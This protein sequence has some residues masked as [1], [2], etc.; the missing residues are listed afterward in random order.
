[1]RI[2]EFVLA[3]MAAATLTVG[4]ARV[5]AAQVDCDWEC[6]TSIGPSF[7]TSEWI[8]DEWGNVGAPGHYDYV[9]CFEDGYGQVW[10]VYYGGGN[11]A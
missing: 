6:L 5:A 10:C 3:A 9:G 4:T 2:R 8:Y 11:A 1:M 7:Y